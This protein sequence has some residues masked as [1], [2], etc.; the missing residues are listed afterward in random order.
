MRGRSFHLSIRLSDVSIVA[1]VSIMLYYHFN[2][3]AKYV[4]ECF[5]DIL[6]PFDPS[7]YDGDNFP[8]RA[9]DEGGF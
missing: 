1:Q 2:K 4:H 8:L 5:T 7:A 6:N 3:F 9:R